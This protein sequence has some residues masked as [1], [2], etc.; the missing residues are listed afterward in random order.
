MKSVLGKYN[1]YITSVKLQCWEYKEGRRLSDLEW[2][3]RTT[4]KRRGLE[5]WA[6][7]IEE[8]DCRSQNPGVGKMGWLG[9]WWTVKFGRSRGSREVEKALV[10]DEPRRGCVSGG[11]GMRA[12]FQHDPSGSKD[13]G[14][15]R[16][17]SRW[18]P[19]MWPHPAPS[20]LSLILAC[21]LPGEWT[22]VMAIYLVSKLS[23]AWALELGQ[24]LLVLKVVLVPLLTVCLPRHFGDSV[25][26]LAIDWSVTT[27]NKPILWSQAIWAWNLTLS[28]TGYM[29]LGLALDLLGPQYSLLKNGD[30]MIHLLELL[31]PADWHLAIRC[32]LLYV[33]LRYSVWSV[34]INIYIIYG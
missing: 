22:R 20:Q 15:W 25:T 28:F 16:Q 27:K 32:A 10:D 31:Y 21:M 33:T 19:L 3:G 14:V 11:N 17:D 18:E 34:V 29:T 2:S 4:G 30:R 5:G 8:E 26:Q 6:E 23:G 1:C 12:V 7:L 9:D 24:P 13:E